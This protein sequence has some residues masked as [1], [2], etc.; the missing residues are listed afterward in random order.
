MKSM[1][2]LQQQPASIPLLSDDILEFHAAR[3]LMLVKLC[4]SGD[5]IDG[6]TKMAKL[7]FFVRYPLFFAAACRAR[8]KNP[9]EVSDAVESRMVRYHYGPWDQRYYHVLAYLAARELLRIEKHGKT[10]GLSLTSVGSE[11]ATELARHPAFEEIAGQMKLVRAEFGK[12][13]GSGLKKLIY[14][15]FS[16]EVGERTMGEVIS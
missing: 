2:N 5:R 4:G 15:V 11:I 10:F 14:E 13:S 8:G 3:L 6:L 1:S 9:G 12:L 7:D 16:K